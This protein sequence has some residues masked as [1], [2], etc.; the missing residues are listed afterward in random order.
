MV[1]VRD[2]RVEEARSVAHIRDAY[3]SYDLFGAKVT[4]A[5][6]DDLLK[7]LGAYV[8]AQRQCVLFSQNMHSL[9]LRLR[10]AKMRELEERPETYVH[11]DGMPLVY[12]SRMTGIPLFRSHRV[13]WVDLIWPLLTCAERENWRLFYLGSETAV[14][15]AATENVRRRFPRLAF[16]ARSGFF[17]QKPGSEGSR[18]IAEAVNGF[19][20]DIVLVG[21]GMGRQEPWILE[22]LASLA[23]ASVCTVGACMEYVAGVVRTPPRWLGLYSLEWVF[24]L[25]ENPRRF[26]RRYLIEPWFLLAHFIIHAQRHRG[27]RGYRR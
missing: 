1:V 18:T 25:V 16:A 5:T 4:P 8:S 24:R 22:H 26:W 23:P 9:Y 13:T 15:E 2:L 12:L 11:V 17:D 19:H 21:L 14:V 20:P 10:S 27:I 3:P 6:L 7:I